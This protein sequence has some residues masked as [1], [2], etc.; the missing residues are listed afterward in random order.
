MCSSK[1]NA[2]A[3]VLPRY[4]MTSTT[5]DAYRAVTVGRCCCGSI[6][7]VE[8]DGSPLLKP[9]NVVVVVVVDYS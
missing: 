4:F 3:V 1:V 8:G 6:G 2:S 9:K 7:Q 5:K